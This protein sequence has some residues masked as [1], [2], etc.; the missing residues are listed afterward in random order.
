MYRIRYPCRI[1]VKLEFSRQILH[2]Y[3]DTKFLENPSFG[4]RVFYAN[5]DR[6][7]DMT[8]LILAFRYFANAPNTAPSTRL[9]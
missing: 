5:R 6:Q 9:M 8:K 4:S 7:T 3:S 1:L 2:K